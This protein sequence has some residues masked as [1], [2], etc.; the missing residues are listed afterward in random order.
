MG[1]NLFLQ[2]FTTNVVCCKH[3]LLCKFVCRIEDVIPVDTT[4]TV[5]RNTSKTRHTFHVHWSAQ[6]TFAAYAIIHVAETPMFLVHCVNSCVHCACATRD[7]NTR[8]LAASSPVLY[9][10]ADDPREVLVFYC[11]RK[12]LLSAKRFLFTL[13]PRMAIRYGLLFDQ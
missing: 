6:T 3:A 11:G 1:T 7:C 4:F 2:Q 10:T 13:D 5:W 9:T 8:Q 12:G